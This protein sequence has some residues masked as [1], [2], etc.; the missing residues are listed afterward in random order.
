LKIR[1]ISLFGDVAGLTG[2]WSSLKRGPLA[3][4][5]FTGFAH[6]LQLI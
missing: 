1:L 6:P 4:V 5:A 2:I 3:T